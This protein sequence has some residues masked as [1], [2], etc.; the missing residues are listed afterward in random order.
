M[1]VSDLPLLDRPQGDGSAYAG[2][3]DCLTTLAA[4]LD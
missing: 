1:P 4:A 3:E 2:G